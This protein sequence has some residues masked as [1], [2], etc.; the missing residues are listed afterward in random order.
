[1]KLAYSLSVQITQT[2]TA[3]LN[4]LLA[5]LVHPEV[6]KKAHAELDEVLG[7]R[8]PT[9]EDRGALPYM[10]AICDEILRWR[11]I[12]PLGVPHAVM[13]DDIYGGYF[14]PKGSTIIGSSW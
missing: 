3:I 6:Q 2:F 10:N 13:Q 9:L 7:D 4:G 14:I 12:V 11:S 1:M 5:M 8:L